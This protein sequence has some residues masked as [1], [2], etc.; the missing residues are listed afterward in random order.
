MCNHRKDRLIGNF[1]YFLR[2]KQDVGGVGGLGLVTKD[3]YGG[4]FILIFRVR[5][6]M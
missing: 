2:E 1:A 6:T 4:Y 3:I 5:D